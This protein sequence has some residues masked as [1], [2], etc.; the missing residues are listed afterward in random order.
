[1]MCGECEHAG[2][3]AGTVVVNPPGRDAR[4]LERRCRRGVHRRMRTTRQSR[5]IHAC[6]PEQ[7]ARGVHV[8]R[9]RI[10]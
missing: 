8:K 9:L 6:F 10:V 1:M 4:R 2:V 3:L 7:A 5:F